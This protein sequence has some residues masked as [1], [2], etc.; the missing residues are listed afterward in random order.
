[1][2]HIKLVAL[3]ARFT[4][5]CLALFYVREKLAAHLPDPDISLC[6]FTIN[7]PYYQIVQNS[8]QGSPEAI[9]FSVYIWNSRLMQRLIRDLA[10]L[11][12]DTMLVLGGPQAPSLFPHQK[13]DSFL[14]TVVHGEIEAIPPRFFTDFQQRKL[15]KSYLPESPGTGGTGF[16]SPYHDNDFASHLKNRSVYYESSRGCPFSCSYCLSAARPGVRHR[17]IDRVKEELN[18]ILKHRPKTVRFVDRTFNDRPERALEIWKFLLDRGT[19]TLFHFE[20]APDRFTREMLDFLATVPPGFFQF[21]IGIQSTNPQ[22]LSAINR[23]T[24]MN[25]VRENMAHLV[26]MDSI[27]L[28]LDLI[29]GLP[30]EDEASFARSFNE[31]FALN[32]HYIQ[33]GLLKVLPDTPISRQVTEFGIRFCSDPPY[34]VL[35]TRWLPAQRLASLYWFGECVE[36]FFNTRY[37]RILWRYLRKIEEDPFTFFYSLTETCMGHDFFTRAPTQDFLNE[38]LVSHGSGRDDWD[39]FRELLA[40]SWMKSGKRQLPDSLAHGLQA[41]SMT[42]I[43]NRLWKSLPQNMPGIYDYQGRDL[44]FKQGIFIG[45][46]K[47]VLDLAGLTGIRGPGYLRFSEPTARSVFAYAETLLLPEESQ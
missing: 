33:M 40:Y 20:I 42:D 3:N 13:G 11:L 8:A 46:S 2:I 24:D 29:L 37:F 36:R 41:E 18:A 47:Q 43:R 38:M 32:P 16:S 34:E 30:H 19:G 1:M 25:L 28:H 5:S 12:P 27:H 10:G 7:D 15:K 44:F 21:E 26:A 6:Q 35:A 22:T 45:F 9:F 39:F 14:H 4:H 31:V 23:K 17:D